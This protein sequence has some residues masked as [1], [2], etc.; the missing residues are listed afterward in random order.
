MNISNKALSLKIQELYEEGDVLHYLPKVGIGPD[1]I[2]EKIIFL[3]NKWHVDFTIKYNFGCCRGC[4]PEAICTAVCVSCGNKTKE[5]YYKINNDGIVEEEI[6]EEK[7]C[8]ENPGARFRNIAG[9][10]LCLINWS[11]LN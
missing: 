9:K 6:I 7:S 3:D 5:I 4:S 2:E 1:T 11:N 8:E 10:K